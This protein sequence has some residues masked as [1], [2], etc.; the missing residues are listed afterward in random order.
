MNPE[1]HSVMRPKEMGEEK[2]IMAENNTAEAEPERQAPGGI[3]AGAAEDISDA[4]I[5]DTIRC[6]LENGDPYDPR[7]VCDAQP[8]YDTKARTFRQAEILMRLKVQGMIVKPYRFIP[9]AEESGAITQLTYILLRK[10]CRMIA[11]YGH[12]YDFDKVTVNFSPTVF[13]S[14]DVLADT[15]RIVKEQGA[16][17]SR[18]C[19]ELTEQALEKD[20][21]V[22]GRIT[23]MSKTG[24]QFYLDDFGAGYS[25][26]A[27]IVAYPFRVIKIDKSLLDSAIENTCMRE[28][29]AMVIR[30]LKKYGY[31]VLVEGVENEEGKQFSLKNNVNLIQGFLYAKPV[32]MEELNRYFKKQEEGESKNG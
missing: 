24:I 11:G 7:V 14:T 16:D 21:E 30:V 23:E 4:D 5:R 29:V 2:K 26:I 32:P 3:S 15:F 31:D 17:P 8:I 27:R 1:K 19:I 10:V 9:Y 20:G 25:S 28:M 12:V 13:C 6:I 22:R 18:I